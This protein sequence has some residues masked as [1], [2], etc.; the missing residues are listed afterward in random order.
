MKYVFTFKSRTGHSG[1]FAPNFYFN[2]EPFLFVYIVKQLT[3]K[4]RRFYKKHFVDF[5]N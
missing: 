3:I 4:V 1:R 5:Q 2:C